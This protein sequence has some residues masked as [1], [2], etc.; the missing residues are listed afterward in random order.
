MV[1]PADIRQ[2]T[3]RPSK[4]A[5]RHCKFSMNRLGNAKTTCTCNACCN[6]QCGACCAPCYPGHRAAT[7]C[8]GG[9]CH[10][11]ACAGIQVAALQ[12]GAAL[13]LTGEIHHSVPSCTLATAV[14]NVA[15]QSGSPLPTF[16]GARVVLPLE[17][18]M[19]C[20]WQQSSAWQHNRKPCLEA[21]AHAAAGQAE[22]LTAALLHACA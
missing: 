9:A 20:S 3:E 6:Q 13:G 2:R 14:A 7:S 5:A 15:L 22:A 8:W 16:W 1:T 10:S 4:L 11:R 21:A 18:L 17:C 19:G 12:N